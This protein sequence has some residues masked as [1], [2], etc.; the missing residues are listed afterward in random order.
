MK[1][2]LLSEHKVI[3]IGRS[4][5]QKNKGEVVSEYWV[6]VD[7]NHIGNK[8]Y[9]SKDTYERTSVGDIFQVARVE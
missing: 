4:E 8:L 1:I 6:E 9:I 2:K 5:T 7:H 3:G